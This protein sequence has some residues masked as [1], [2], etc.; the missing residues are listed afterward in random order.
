MVVVVV[1]VRGGCA[2]VVSNCK[3]AA[4]EI[5]SVPVPRWGTALKTIESAF[6]E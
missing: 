5:S 1:V 4:L 6:P 3:P 2:Y